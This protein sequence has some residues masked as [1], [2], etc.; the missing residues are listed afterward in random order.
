MLGWALFAF[1]SA[2]PPLV[3]NASEEADRGS[4]PSGG[5]SASP[6]RL[7][8]ADAAYLAFGEAMRK[9]KEAG[10]LLPPKHVLNTPTRLMKSEGYASGYEYDHDAPEA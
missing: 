5:P 3:A 4:A 8:R 9:A 1:V 7:A 6:G 2:A 10:S